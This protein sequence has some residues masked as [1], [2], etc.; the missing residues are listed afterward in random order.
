MNRKILAVG[1][2]L[3]FIGIGII[4]TSALDTEK[5]LPTSRGHWLYVGGSGPG[6]YT[7]IQDAI[8]NASNGDTVFVYDDS[9]PYY[10]TIKIN[11]SLNLIGENR[12]TTIIDGHT[13]DCNIEIEAENVTISDFTI[14]NSSRSGI[15]VRRVS[16]ITITNNIIQNN[17]A[18]G[19]SLTESMYS[20]INRN[21]IQNNGGKGISI[22]LYCRGNTI[23]QN[24]IEKNKIGIEA[25]IGGDFHLI[26]SE[27][28]IADSSE[29]GLIIDSAYLSIVTKNNFERNTQNGYITFRCAYD[30]PSRYISLF[31]TKIYSKSLIIIN[32]YWDGTRFFPYII[33][34]QIILLP[35]FAWQQTL[36]YN[37]WKVDWHPAQE[38]YDI[39]GTT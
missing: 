30:P 39:R 29:T 19:I 7:K 9:S 1:I 37:C 2:I 11:K 13:K 20:I 15:L 26:I 21:I 24:I 3:L 28:K 34:A 22:F 32:N 16:H 25:T 35:F 23:T 4:P 18:E 8:D 12:D 31:L 38:H 14:Q 17:L 27:N 33:D 10:E 36:Y 6:N 5:S